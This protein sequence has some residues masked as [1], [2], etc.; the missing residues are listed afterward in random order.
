M[1]GVNDIMD[2]LIHFE[3]TT[4]CFLGCL[5]RV[6]F[7]LTIWQIL[8]DVLYEFAWDVTFKSTSLWPSGALECWNPHIFCKKRHQSKGF[9][10]FWKVLFKWSKLNHSKTRIVSS[11]N[12]FLFIRLLE[13]WFFE[14]WWRWCWKLDQ[15]CWLICLIED[16]QRF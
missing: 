12:L 10:Y 2:S 8:N 14:A 7:W 3:I 9:F 13:Q 6:P 4:V 16:F 1:T 11:L 15:A 5:I